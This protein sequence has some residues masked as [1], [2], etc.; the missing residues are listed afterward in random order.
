VIFTGMINPPF[1]AV[2]ALY[3]LQNP[4]I[5]T[6]C[7]PNAG[8]TGGAGVAF[9]AGKANLINALIFFAVFT[10]KMFLYLH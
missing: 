1:S 7:C 6:P 9:P 2:R 8:P 4:A 3:S 10:F 5:F